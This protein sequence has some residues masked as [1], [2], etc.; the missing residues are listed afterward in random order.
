[1]ICRCSSSQS[2][3]LPFFLLF[4]LLK[5]YKPIKNVL[6]LSLLPP[7]YCIHTHNLKNL[8]FS[9]LNFSFVFKLMFASFSWLFTF[10]SMYS[11]LLSP[12]L[13]HPF[14]KQWWIKIQIWHICSQLIPVSL[15]VSESRQLAWIARNKIEHSYNYDACHPTNAPWFFITE[16]RKPFSGF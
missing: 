7:T 1:M 11:N 10:K 5:S 15:L 3:T 8:D 16:K 6:P 12:H 9:S 2:S 4:F 13:T 14:S